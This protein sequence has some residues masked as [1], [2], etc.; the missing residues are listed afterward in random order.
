MNYEDPNLN[1]AIPVFSIHGNHDDPSGFGRLSSLD[2]LSTSGLVNYFGRWTDLTQV[3]I[4]P[5]LMRKGESQLALY[6]LSHI[7]DGRLARLIKDF[8][9]K[10]NCPE[11]VANGEDGNESKEEEDWFHLLV[12]HQ[13]RAD[14]GPKNYLPED[15]LPSFLHL[16]I[17]GHEH[18][19]RI[20]PEE[21]AKKRFYVS[22]PGSSVPTSL[23]EGEA[24]KS[25][26]A[27][28]RSTRE[29]SSLSRFRWRLYGPSSL[30]PSYWPTMPTN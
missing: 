4:S 22:Q 10:F 29:N 1:I 17:W 12:V 6:G 7:H 9:V 15:L 27:C 5:V 30:N 25:T 20:E 18:D 23:S 28:S 2:L 26:S 19:C 21:N 11:N 3:E 8:K 24:K 14:R 16:V 13:N